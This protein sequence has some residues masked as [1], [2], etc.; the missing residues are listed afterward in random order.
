MALEEPTPAE[1]H[2]AYIYAARRNPLALAELIMAH[3]SEQ[4][5]RHP[6]HV[7][8]CRV[9]TACAR[10]GRNVTVHFPP[11]HGK[12]TQLLAVLIHLLAGNPA[13]RIAIVSASDLA[14]KH[15]IR[16]RKALVGRVVQT[17]HPHLSPDLAK[18]S[19]SHG[20][21][22]KTKLYLAGEDQ[23]AF[24]VLPLLGSAEG[25]RFDVIY[26]DDA[27]NQKGLTSEAERD[28]TKNAVFGTFLNRLTPG[29]FVAWTNNCWH[30]EDAFH[31]A[32]DSE[33][34]ATLWVAYRGTEAITWQLR[35][36]PGWNGETEGEWPLWE[37]WPTERLREKRL[38]SGPF[39]TRLYEGRA[40]QTEDCRFPSRD[41]WARYTPEEL[42]AAVESGGQFFGFLDPAGG[43]RADK[44]DWAAVTAILGTRDNRAFVVAC[45][46]ERQPPSAQVRACFDAEAVLRHDWGRGFLRFEVEML[47]KDEGWMQQPFDLER[48]KRAAG[49][50]GSGQLPWRIRNPKE[51]KE[52]RIERL[53]PPLENGWLLWPK[54]LAERIEQATP[55]GRSWR[56]LVEMIEEW[57]MSDHDDGPDS[58]AGAVAMALGAPPL[59]TV[60]RGRLGI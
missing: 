28:R 54:D 4:V 57:P 35:D 48:E 14:E 12:S 49:N 51:P 22:S 29:G 23:P 27:C 42:K 5:R 8:L 19:A 3:N 32:R 59:G 50:D 21:W 6:M 15:L 60:D 2:R 11:E 39:Y 34:F 1:I 43:K 18:S 33:G 26:L 17:V 31:K 46:I 44:G 36:M 16:V 56:R 58:L 25:H 45:W 52:S 24:Q 55:H 47:P 10:A 37:Q 53:G 9:V 20:E 30:R 7:L 38:E 40:V 13:L 41:H